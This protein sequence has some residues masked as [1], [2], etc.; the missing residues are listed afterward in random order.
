[1]TCFMWFE[2]D[3]F[4]TNIV[5]S[6]STNYIIKP[7]CC[8]VLVFYILIVC[9]KFLC[10]TWVK[11][12]I[13]S[14]SIWYH[15]EDYLRY[16]KNNQL[17]RHISGIRCASN[18]LPINNLRKYNI[19]RQE[20][21]CNMCNE[22]KLGNELHIIMKCNNNE[23][24]KFRAHLLQSINNL[25]SQ[26]NMLS[27]EDR[28][29]YMLLGVDESITIQFSYFLNNVYKTIKLETQKKRDSKLKK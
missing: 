4:K 25:C 19:K 27:D 2:C 12:T 15:Q 3:S 5:P 10:V 20:R 26:F 9:E 11:S 16:I 21:F 18:I 14:T 23:L 22:K 24:L 6:F 8:T 29:I 17:K 13:R 28:L 7:K 1:M